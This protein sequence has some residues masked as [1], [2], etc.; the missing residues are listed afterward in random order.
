[1]KYL[2]NLEKFLEGRREKMAKTGNKNVETKED[3]KLQTKDEIMKLLKSRE[4][5]EV[6]EDGKNDLSVY[7]G[8][9]HIIQIMIRDKITIQDK[10]EKDNKKNQKDFDYD[11]W[12]QIKKELA[13]LIDKLKA[14]NNE[15]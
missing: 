15:D 3:K 12:G 13:R 11:K 1:M 4:N 8:E 2:N 9:K 6:K 5:V 10:N 7:V 14:E